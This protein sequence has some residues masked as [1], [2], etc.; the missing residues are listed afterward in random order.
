[1]VTTSEI[2]SLANIVTP[3]VVG[4]VG[5]LVR[6]SMGRITDRIEAL[7]RKRDALELEVIELRRVSH[8]EV[9]AAREASVS[10]IDWIR[11]SSR[12]RLTLERLVEGQAR[13]EGR[14]DMGTRIATAI[15]R[16]NE[17]NGGGED[18]A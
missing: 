14:M 8:A 12:M 2:I 13:L 9:D 5:W 18:G 3:I 16:L 15:E 11:E 4:V 6:Q 10:R 7:E 17:G 1:M